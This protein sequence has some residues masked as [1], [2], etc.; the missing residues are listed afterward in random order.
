MIARVMCNLHRQPQRDCQRCRDAH[1]MNLRLLHERGE[2]MGPGYCIGCD[3][4]TGEV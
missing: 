2:C 1:E 4:M 3:L